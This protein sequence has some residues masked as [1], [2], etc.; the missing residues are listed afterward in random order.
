MKGLLIT[1]YFPPVNAIASHRVYSFAK[2]LNN[3]NDVLDVICPEWEGD[4][5]LPT[6]SF[7]V[8][9]CSKHEYDPNFGEVKLMGMAKVK[10]LIANKFFKLNLFRSRKPGNFCKEVISVL[11]TLDISE[12]DY[13]ITSYAPLDCI[14]VGAY[15]KLKYPSIKWLI[16]YRD[17]YSQVEYTDFGW[18]RKNFTKFERK[19]TKSADGFITVSK[20]L[21]LLQEKILSIKGEVV[22][23]GFEKNDNQKKDEIV[24]L[25][26]EIKSY[27]LPVISYAG[28]LYKGER[29][30]EPFLK[31]LKEKGLDKKFV[32]IFAILNDF[33]AEYLNNM[34]IKTKVAN[35]I[36][37]RNLNYME[38]YTLQLNSD[39]LLLLTNSDGRANGY[40][41]GKV[42][43][44]MASGK[45]I[46][47]SGT[48]SK[49]Y[50]LYDIVKTYNLGES[51][52]NFDYE[53][54]Q[55]YKPSNCEFFQRKIQAKVLEKYITGK[56]QKEINE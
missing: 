36:I 25:K 16:D 30:V 32:T 9:K 42:F 10:N 13:I 37:K 41:T 22:Y 53:N 24:L 21:K 1:Y 50:E 33:D 11:D 28:S 45:P 35:V 29:D 17:V 38:S 52:S 23:N 19:L 34:I 54:P 2:Y 6:D 47:Y 56:L 7:K 18:A 39:L 55:Q 8:F 26:Q 3:G 31:H 15:I 49:G 43:E 40:L 27:K 14:H 12:Y 51:F 48:T 5:N 4:L 46:I 20:T 44:Y